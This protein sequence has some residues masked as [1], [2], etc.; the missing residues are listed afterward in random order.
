M[1]VH[2]V[3]C[4]GAVPESGKHIRRISQS[5]TAAH[6]SHYHR[7]RTSS[8]HAWQGRFKSPVIEAGDYLLTVM[9]YVESN[10]LRAGMVSHLATYA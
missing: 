7:K 3:S 2:I 5:L 9:R 6:A 8:G 4:G 10:P 1:S